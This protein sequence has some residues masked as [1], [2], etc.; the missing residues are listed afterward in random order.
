AHPAGS[1]RT[2]VNQVQLPANLKA[3]FGCSAVSKVN[4]TSPGTSLSDY[5]CYSSGRDSYNFQAFGNVDITSQ[6]RSKAWVVG[7]YNLNDTIETYMEFF[8]NKTQSASAIAP[9]PIDSLGAPLVIAANNYYNPFGVTF[10][11]SAAGGFRF[12]TRSIG[13]GNRISNFSTTV[14]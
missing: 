3:Q 6:G 10:A 13:N 14:D 8:H 4:V 5:R 2:P 1:S 7:N 11:D 9:Q 12:K